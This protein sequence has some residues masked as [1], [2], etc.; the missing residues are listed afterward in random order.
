MARV[1]LVYSIPG[2]DPEG[3]GVCVYLESLSRYL[4][5]NPQ[6]GRKDLRIREQ[7]RA[8]Y[9]EVVEIPA[10]HL[11]DREAMRR[12][13]YRLGKLLPGKEK[14]RTIGDGDWW[15]NARKP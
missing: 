6:T 1:A 5:G 14:A 11:H 8:Q 4:H 10:S 12:H 9:Y 15:Y 7:L 3:P 13:F 2:D